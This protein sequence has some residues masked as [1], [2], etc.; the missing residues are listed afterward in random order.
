[1]R[2]VMT[3]AISRPGTIAVR[4]ADGS[5]VARL[6]GLAIAS[7]VPA[8]FW[9]MLIEVAAIWIGAPLAPL[10]LAFTCAAITLFL[11]AVCAPLIL[12]GSI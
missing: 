5:R 8:A 9:S 3:S 10:T 4:R 12:R 6:A 2:A 7:F 1:M 11:A